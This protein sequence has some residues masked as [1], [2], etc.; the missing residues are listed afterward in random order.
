[1]KT[2]PSF[3]SCRKT[4]CVPKQIAPNL[5]TKLQKCGELI[6]SVESCGGSL[7]VTT[8]MSSNLVHVPP[9]SDAAFLKRIIDLRDF[10]WAGNFKQ[11]W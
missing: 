5:L 10:Q 11:G 2:N 9:S 1:M 4:G 7:L 3:T 8:I 6:W